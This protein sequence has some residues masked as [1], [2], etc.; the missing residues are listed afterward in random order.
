MFF[1]NLH[2][3]FVTCHEDYKNT[4][5]SQVM[6][7]VFKTLLVITIIFM[8]YLCWSSIMTPIRLEKQKAVREEAVKKELLN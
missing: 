2:K 7:I 8:A 3:L 1:L 4:T 6:R 5:I